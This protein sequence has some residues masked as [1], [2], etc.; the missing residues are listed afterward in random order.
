MHSQLTL[1]ATQ[2]RIN[3]LSLAAAERRVPERPFSPRRWPHRRPISRVAAVFA[4][5]SAARA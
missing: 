4:R 3:D 2:Q 5:I 1:I